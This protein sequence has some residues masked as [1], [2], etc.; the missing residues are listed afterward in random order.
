MSDRTKALALAGLCIAVACESEAPQG[1]GDSAAGGTSSG[2]SGSAGSAQAGSSG[3]SAGSAGQAAG[4][5][6][7]AGGG[8]GGVGG[9][10]A[11]A[12]GTSGE[13]GGDGEGCEMGCTDGLTCHDELGCVRVCTDSVIITS[14]AELGAF[15]AR[16][17]QVLEGSLSVESATLLNLDALAPSQ[18]VII[19]GDLGIEDNTALTSIQGLSGLERVLGSVFITDNAALVRLERSRG[20]RHRRGQRP[21]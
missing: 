20:T 18:L 8:A 6:G 15:A 13:G 10:T 7:S 3:S 11:G 21:R 2:V 5:A 4:T 17:C 12:S 19:T 16:G 1:D 14:E 9:S